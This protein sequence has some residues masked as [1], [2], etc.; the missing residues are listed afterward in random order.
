MVQN[1]LD[2]KGIQEAFIRV[3]NTIQAK[4][5]SI[6]VLESL[7]T[8]AFSISISSKLKNQ[9]SVNRLHGKT[10]NILNTSLV[11]KQNIKNTIKQNK[12]HIVRL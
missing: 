7:L 2:M 10:Y 4:L 5:P 1:I 11:T 6:K 12:D 9:Q 8:L 3:K